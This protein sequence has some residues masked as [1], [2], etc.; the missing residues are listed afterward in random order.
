MKVEIDEIMHSC[1]LKVQA[2]KNIDGINKILV[3]VFKK[4]SDIKLKR[5]Q[6]KKSETK[7][8]NQQQHWS[9]GSCKTLEMEQKFKYR[10]CFL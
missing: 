6:D 7:C 9:I 8:V 5:T 2:L 3:K 4:S 10:K 1:I